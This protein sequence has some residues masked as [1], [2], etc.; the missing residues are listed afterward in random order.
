[1][2]AGEAQLM[3]QE[4]AQQQSRLDGSFVASPIDVDG[5][6][7]LSHDPDPSVVLLLVRRGGAGACSG[8]PVCGSPEGPSAA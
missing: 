5:N 7:A 4:V 3:P 6:N 8:G 1:M 2:G